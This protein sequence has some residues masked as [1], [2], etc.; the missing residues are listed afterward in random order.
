[1]VVDRRHL[2]DL[3][4]LG[5]IA[6]IHEQIL[7]AGAEPELVLNRVVTDPYLEPYGHDLSLGDDF[8]F[9]SI[10]NAAHNRFP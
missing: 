8:S 7:A 4:V 6:W 5:F 2:A 3:A 9:G 1:M 10:V